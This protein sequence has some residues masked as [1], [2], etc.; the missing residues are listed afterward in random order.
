MA[1]AHDTSEAPGRPLN[2]AETAQALERL[3]GHRVVMNIGRHPRVIA[4]MTG[5]LRVVEPIFIAQNWG[6]VGVQ[7]DAAYYVDGGQD[8]GHVPA[9]ALY[10]DDTFA[11]FEDGSGRVGWTIGDTMTVVTPV[12]R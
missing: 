10:D 6:D 3:V 12:E 4:S 9:V 7:A 11:G 2:F 1:H 5:L 8:T